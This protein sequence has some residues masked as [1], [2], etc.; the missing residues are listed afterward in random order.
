[1][2]FYVT[3]YQRDTRDL[4]TEQHGI[5]FKLILLAWERGGPIPNDHDFIN[6]CLFHMHGNQYNSKVKPILERFFTIGDDD[7]F[8]QKR[9]E[10]ELEKSR[11]FS[12]KQTENAGKRW[13]K[14]KDNNGIADATALPVPASLQPQPQLGLVP[15]LPT[16]ASEHSPKPAKP[17]RTRN[18]YPEKFEEFWSGYPTDANM[19]KVEAFKAWGR[20]TLADQEL[21]TKSL[22]AFRAYCSS[23][24]DYRPLHANR[25]LAQRRFE[26][27]AKVA[28]R[29][30]VANFLVKQESPCGRAWEKHYRET[31]GKGVPWQNGAWRFP[32]EWPQDAVSDERIS[33]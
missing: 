19:A 16:E 11:N 15:T 24:P 25:Y 17:V 5:Y 7:V 13:S 10:K 28:E 9:V 32:S 3:D 14:S 26:G 18:A 21:A 22:P 30:A 27:H 4:T 33:A 2:P 20:L 6:R 31:R 8:R 23:H 1:M 12:R 29:S